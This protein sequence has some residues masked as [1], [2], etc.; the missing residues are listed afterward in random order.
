MKIKPFLPLLRWL[1]PEFRELET[2]ASLAATDPLTSLLNRR[3]AEDQLD[4]LLH[5]LDRVGRDRMA[6]GD[7][8]PFDISIAII[9]GNNIKKLN[10]TIGH[11]ETDKVI[12]ALAQDIS[13]AFR[14]AEDVVC[15][16]GGDEFCVYLV[17][18]TRKD[19]AAGA[20]KLDAIL[21]DDG[22]LS[23]GGY[24]VTAAIGI[25]HGYFVRKRG[26]R[27]VIEQ[28]LPLADKAM[29]VAKNA[30]KARTTISMAEEDPGSDSAL[31]N[32]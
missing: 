27:Q 11:D 9:D 15:R 6:M 29:Y 5:A 13:L 26:A 25:A 20:H 24:T 22:R 1:F 3:G 23:V 4:R 32:L 19:A 30:G 8:K 31:G 18:A 17:N 10:D 7:P 16:I 2:Q 14:R 21:R 28:I 12:Q